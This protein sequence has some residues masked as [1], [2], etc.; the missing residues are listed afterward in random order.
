ML[1]TLPP[2]LKP[3]LA[4]ALI[5]ELKEKQGSSSGE[6]STLSLPQARGA[7]PVEIHLG[8]VAS[9]SMEPLSHQ[10][11]HTMA[12]RSHLTGE[13]QSVLFGDLRAKFGNKVIEPNLQKEMPQHNQ[14][15]SQYFS[16]EEKQMLDSDDKLIPKHVFFCNNTL[17]FLQEVC[18]KRGL[19]WEQVMPLLTGDSGQQGCIFVLMPHRS[20]SERN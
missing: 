2:Q 7:W 10:E 16:V 17:A 3:Q 18:V 15:Y 4:E 13:Q 19:V 6:I 1:E 8:S 5:R 12:S 9:T 20:I 14:Q 11:V